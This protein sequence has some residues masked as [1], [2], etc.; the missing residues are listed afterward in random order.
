MNHKTNNEALSDE[1]LA[2]LAENVAPVNL[3][4]QTKKNMLK[5]IKCGIDGA[6]PEGGKTIFSKNSEWQTLSKYISVKVLHQ[7]VKNKIQIAIWKL[8]PGANIQSHQHMNDEECLVLEGTI[9][10]GEHRLAAGDFH[11]MQKD[12]VHPPITT[13]DGALL[14]LKH[15]LCEGMPILG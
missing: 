1:Q 4:N 11:F 14:Y 8:Q 5:M 12:S 9:R 6:C 10:I 3:D 15:D 13:D 2:L 7:D